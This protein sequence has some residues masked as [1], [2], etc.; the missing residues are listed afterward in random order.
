MK[1]QL[2]ALV[3]SIVMLV[4]VP[5]YA[6]GLSG[7]FSESTQSTNKT[8]KDSLPDPGEVLEASGELMQSNYNFTDDYICDVYTYEIPTNK[9]YFIRQY[10][11][12]VTNAGFTI[13][14][15]ELEGNEAYMIEDEN[16]SSYLVFAKGENAMLLLVDVNASFEPHIE[17][18]LEQYMESD[19]FLEPESNYAIVTVGDETI[20]FYLDKCIKSSDCFAAYYQSYNLFGEKQYRLIIELSYDINA[21]NYTSNDFRYKGKAS[22][23]MFNLH[24]Y[25][26]YLHSSDEYIN[27]ASVYRGLSDNDYDLKILNKSEDAKSYDL[28]V[29]IKKAKVIGAPGEF[30]SFQ[31]WANYTFDESNPVVEKMKEFTN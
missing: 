25:T 16:S 3:M 4:S 11:E 15:G 13:T 19:E 29:D 1:K 7:L 9:S 22:Q 21:G 18:S 14:E 2:V 5:V 20:L 6:D 8:G 10:K 31:V 23:Y 12:L 26:K 27:F 30:K 24:I 17:M 28:S